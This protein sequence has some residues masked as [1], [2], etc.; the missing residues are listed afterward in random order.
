MSHEPT[1]HPNTLIFPASLDPDAVKTVERLNDGGFESYLVGGCV[2]DL[3]MG[4]IPKDFDVSTAARPR[5]V[6][7]LFRNC[8]V[9]GRR[10]KLAHVHFGDKIIEVSTF[11][12]PPEAEGATGDGDADDEDD[13][14]LLIVQDNEFGTAEQ[15]VIR[16]DFTI[17]ALLYDVRTDEVIDYVGGVKDVENRVLRTIG[18]PGVRLAEDPVRMLRAIKFTARAHLTLEDGLD[19]AM[20]DSAE[21][22]GRSAPPRVLEEIFKL[23]ACGGAERSLSM[24]VEYGLLEHL[25]PEIA[26]YWDSHRDELAR[27]GAALDRIDAGQRRLKNGFLLAAL[28]HAPWNAAVEA[29]ESADAAALAR[30]LIAPAA[31]RMSI[32]RRDVATCKQLLVTQLRLTR[33]RR[34]RRLRMGEFLGRASTR[35][36]IQLLYL[37]C[38]AGSGDPE[39]HARW[40]QRLAEREVELGLAGRDTTAAATRGDEETPGTG[41]RRR[42]GARSRRG[43]ERRPDDDRKTRDTR[44]GDSAADAE[45]ASSAGPEDEARSEGE[46]RPKRS[47]SRRRGGARR[48]GRGGA[49]AAAREPREGSAE[50]P[51]PMPRKPREVESGSAPPTT[52]AA[53]SA[54]AAEPARGDSG[55]APAPAEEP[56]RGL[57]GFVA[58]LI[59]KV[60]GEDTSAAASADSAETASGSTSTSD[61]KRAQGWARANSGRDSQHRGQAGEEGDSANTAETS[62]ATGAAKDTEGKPDGRT[63]RR[64][65]GRSRGGRGRSRSSGADKSADKSAGDARGAEGATPRTAGDAEAASSGG[66]RSRRGR[67]GKQGGRSGGGAKSGGRGKSG[68]GAKS[69]GN[70]KSASKTRSRSSSRKE[71]PEEPASTGQ[72]HPE[73]VEDMF[74]W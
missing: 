44:D 22:I 1:R 32:A 70:G 16:R 15:D 52:E 29:D 28:Y 12:R 50:A 25:L 57:R 19:T 61:D 51:A 45:R 55:K 18:E 65:R 7:R 30:D 17:N 48:G 9:I 46:P 69:T 66:S 5:Q 26:P 38:L 53:A 41:R 13:E 63:P 54:R 74:D 2:R 62:E 58:K 40:A 36:A 6:R 24:L 68:G 37:T 20:R 49:S 43:G 67:S 59:R 10:F 11:R 34:S 35:D 14:D 47:R 8:R 60:K 23:L 71:K 39:V 56:P 64:R 21:L 72:R 42:R 73:D 27:V 3:L 31:L 4:M 33:G